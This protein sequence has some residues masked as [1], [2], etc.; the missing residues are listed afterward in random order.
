MN[1][2]FAEKINP[3]LKSFDF[4][5]ALQIA[6]EELK[7]LPITPF[8]AVIGR[9]LNHLTRPLASWIDNFYCAA[10]KTTAVCAL[11]FELNEF[12]I[13]TDHWFIQGFAYEDC[14]FDS[15]DMDWLCDFTTDAHTTIGSGFY[16]PDYP[17]LQTAFSEINSKKLEGN[18]TKE[19]QHARDWCE[20]IIIIRFMELM[21][22][23]HLFAKNTCL[24][25]SDIPILFTEHEYDFIVKSE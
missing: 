6:E 8:H 4:D 20:Q 17:D 7:R 22:N 21:R 2:N 5:A 11:Y 3:S 13:N 24:S 19:M 15:D 18:C 9:S 23:S 10:K 12:D 1:F 25:W 14:E 16:L